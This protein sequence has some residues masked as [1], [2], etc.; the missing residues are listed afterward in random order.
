MPRAYPKDARAALTA[1]AR[2]LRADGLTYAALGKRLG[3]SATGA[4]Y[5]IGVADPHGSFRRGIV[6]G[7]RPR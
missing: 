5:L 7:R 4:R 3:V 6:L 1:E 2:R